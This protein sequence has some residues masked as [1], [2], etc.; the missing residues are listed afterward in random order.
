[1]IYDVSR[2]GTGRYIA[3]N[4]RDIPSR[5]DKR[6]PE[7]LPES[8]ELQVL[9]LINLHPGT[10]LST[11]VQLKIL[12]NAEIYISSTS[13]FNELDDVDCCVSL[14]LLSRVKV[15]GGLECSTP[16]TVLCPPLL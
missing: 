16:I 13:F 12:L 3:K 2:K 5:I 7:Q 6:G 15:L 9:S 8:K 1:M 11:R 14:D 10:P 4:E